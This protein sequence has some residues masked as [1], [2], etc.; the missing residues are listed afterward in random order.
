MSQSHE[1][2]QDSLPTPSRRQFLMQASAI[3]D[4]VLTRTGDEIPEILTTSE[5]AKAYYGSIKENLATFVFEGV[6]MNQVCAEAALEFDQIVERRRIVNWGTNPDVQNRI[7]Q[8][9]E[10]YL[11]DLKTRTGMTFDFDTIDKILDTCLDIAKV[12]RP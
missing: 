9:F 3:M 10:D 6:A 1:A 12:R 5:T 8:D 7:R 11:F 4:L 2:Q